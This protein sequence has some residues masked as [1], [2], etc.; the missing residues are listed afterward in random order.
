MKN[1]MAVGAGA[2][3]RAWPAPSSATRA[4]AEASQPSRVHRVPLDQGVPFPSRQTRTVEARRTPK[5]T[6]QATS[7]AS[8]S[9]LS[10]R[11]RGST[12]P[13]EA[14]PATIMNRASQRRPVR[15]ATRVI[16]CR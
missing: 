2:S 5:A 4:T 14:A 16:I 8:R 11:R 3:P 6:A 9:R 13:P 15:V 10:G 1:R 7:T 12:S